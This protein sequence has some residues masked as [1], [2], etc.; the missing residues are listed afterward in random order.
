MYSS[1]KLTMNLQNFTMDL[2]RQSQNLESLAGRQRAKHLQGIASFGEEAM[3]RT[4]VRPHPC[5][6][7]GTI[8]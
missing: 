5:L 8:F 2:W 3:F 6:L 1:T 4:G 7:A